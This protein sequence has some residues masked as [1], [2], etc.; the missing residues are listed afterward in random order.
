MIVVQSASRLHFGLLGFPSGSHWPNHRG[1]E[2]IPARRF[3]GAGLMVQSPGIELGMRDAK[4]WLASGPLADRALEFAHRFADTSETKGSP[5]EITIRHCAP[6]HVGLGTG[7]QLGLAV[8]RGLSLA[9]DHQLQ[10]QELCHR[11]GRGARSALGFY[12]FLHGGVL[13]E[14]GKNRDSVIAPLLVRESFP[15]EWRVVLVI[16]AEA[17]GL[18]GIKEAEAVEELLAQ[19]IP[20]KYTESMCRLVL[21]GMLPAIKERDFKSFGESLGDLNYLA[22]QV[23]ARFQGGNYRPRISEI[24]EFVKGQDIAG[25]GQSSWGPTVF[26]MTEDEPRA[27]D[28]AEKIRENFKLKEQEVLLTSAC[29]HGASAS[30]ISE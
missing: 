26:A 19:G 11:V 15:E 30:V 14:G 21:L 20:L 9:W 22:G 16:P 8:A 6:E 10:P 28:L 7:T 5:Q 27:T 13:V 12:G 29:N 2:S 23:F 24:I 1:E 25:V 4:N 17:A 3:G 18:S